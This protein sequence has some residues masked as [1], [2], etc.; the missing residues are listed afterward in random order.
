[1]IEIL[2]MT[3]NW[4]FPAFFCIL[5]YFDLRKKMAGLT[6]V[7]T[8]DLVHVIAKDSENTAKVEKVMVE[9]KEVGVL[10]YTAINNLTAEIRRMNEKK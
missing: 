3:M 8:N 1:M 9:V 4:G 5:W 6:T 7:I 10:T 2:K